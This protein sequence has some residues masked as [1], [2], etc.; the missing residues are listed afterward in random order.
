MNC[1]WVRVGQ[2]GQRAAWVILA[3]LLLTAPMSAAWAREGQSGALKVVGKVTNGTPEGEVPVDLTV[4]LHVFS[5]IEERSTFTTTLE[6][7]R[8]FEFPDI[9]Y[10]GGET[11]VARVVYAGVTYVSEFLTPAASQNNVSARIVIYET[12]DDPGEI[13]VGQLHVFVQ[14]RGEQIQIGQYAVISNRGIRTYV[15]LPRPTTGER[16]TWAVMLPDEAGNLEINGG[17]LGE[18]FIALEGGFAD[19]R[20]IQ[21]GDMSVEASFSYDLPYREGLLIEQAFDVPVKSVVLVVRGEDLHLQGATLSP[22]G[23][24]DTEMGPAAAYTAGA[25][26]AGEPLRFAVARPEVS[27]LITLTADPRHGLAVGL[28]ALLAA[29][30]AA[31]WLLRSASPGPVPAK[32][33]REVAA[34]AALDRG[35]ENGEIREKDYREQRNALKQRVRDS[36]LNGNR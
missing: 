20:A 6:P 13:A 31:Y 10:E 34:L 11:L 19:T 26:A 12:T 7:D 32:V 21:P 36:L 27:S 1:P 16:T 24:L 28:M 18:R 35:F 5:G 15:G 3:C 23:K 25:L 33:R 14:S 9:E 22:E 4:T 8:S 17:G 2:W 29:G 30:V